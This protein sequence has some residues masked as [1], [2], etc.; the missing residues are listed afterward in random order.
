MATYTI[1]VH[2]DR[3]ELLLIRKF[4]GIPTSQAMN[5]AETIGLVER[6]VNDEIGQSFRELRDEFAEPEPE[7]VDALTYEEARRQ[8]VAFSEQALNVHA[9]QYPATSIW[10]RAARDEIADRVADHA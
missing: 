5:L 7:H 9:A 3:E 2:V 6:F 10:G 8:Y 1:Q 4:H